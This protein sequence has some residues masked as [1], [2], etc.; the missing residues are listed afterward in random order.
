[1]V[2]GKEGLYRVPGHV[3]LGK[4]ASGWPRDTRQRRAFAECQHMALGKEASFAECQGAWHSAK[5]PNWVP[6]F[7]ALPSAMAPLPNVPLGKAGKFFFISAF[8]IHISSHT[9]QCITS[10]PDFITQ[11]TIYIMFISIIHT[12]RHIS[13]TSIIQAKHNINLS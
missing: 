12:S 11:N 1:M 5:W 8:H 6:G 2:L 3:A 7:P 9:T 13:H 10:H 4:E